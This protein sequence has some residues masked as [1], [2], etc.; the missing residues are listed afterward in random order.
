MIRIFR[1][2]QKNKINAISNGKFLR[3]T[4]EMLGKKCKCNKCGPQE[5]KMNVIY[6][7]FFPSL[8]FGNFSSQ[9]LGNPRLFLGLGP[10]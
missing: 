2:F 1:I 5:K 8:M 9:F 7:L 4:V 3:E 6:S 10:F